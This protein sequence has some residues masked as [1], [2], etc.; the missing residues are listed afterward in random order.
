MIVEDGVVK[1]IAIEPKPTEAVVS[2][3]EKMLERMAKA[4][5]DRG[6]AKTGV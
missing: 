6:S 1:D 2:S 5:L 4:Y 3:A